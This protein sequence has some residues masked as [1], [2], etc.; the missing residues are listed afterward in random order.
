[1]LELLR[2]RDKTGTPNPSRLN[3][4]PVSLPPGYLSH[5]LS[6][7][8]PHF[9]IPFFLWRTSAPVLL[10][11]SPFLFS[12]R[13]KRW[14][15]W[16]QDKGII[17]GE[18]SRP[19]QG[20]LPHRAAYSNNGITGTRHGSDHSHEVQRTALSSQGTSDFVFNNELLQLTEKLYQLQTLW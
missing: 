15:S 8:L 14:P 4:L 18:E 2:K 13:G 19:S 5:C 17:L 6:A 7:S 1:M 10:L 16:L 11:L 3:T 9:P 12:K 20:M